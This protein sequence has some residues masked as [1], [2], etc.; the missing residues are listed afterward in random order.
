MLGKKVL[1]DASKQ[2]VII[3]FE[4]ESIF[5]NLHHACHYLILSNR[6]ENN[7]NDDAN[8][9]VAIN[10]NC[11]DDNYSFHHLDNHLNQW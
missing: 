7:D 8:F 9:V 6:K 3:M 10:N 11:I 5:L 1:N 4:Q 2:C